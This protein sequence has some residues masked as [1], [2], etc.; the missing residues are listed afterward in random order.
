MKNTIIILLLLGCFSTY[1]LPV[2]DS[3]S[4]G[5]VGVDTGRNHRF[6]ICLETGNAKVFEVFNTGS[7]TTHT[8]PHTF[9]NRPIIG[10]DKGAF[11][12]THFSSVEIGNNII[13]IR[14]SAFHG[15]RL[16]SVTIPKSV[17][18]IGE[19]AFGASRNLKRISVDED[20]PF[21]TEKS[22]V[23][24]NKEKTILIAYPAGKEGEKYIIPNSVEVIFGYAFSETN[25]SFIV[26]PESVKKIRAFSFQHNV[27]LKKIS[28]FW[29]EPEMLNVSRFAFWRFPFYACQLVID[30]LADRVSNNAAL[31]YI[32]LE[33]PFGTKERYL[34]LEPWKHFQIIER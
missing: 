34:A 16:D 30:R 11:A 8:I 26:I 28:V 18:F 22:G 21:F 15:S 32:V 10:I 24:F 5:T 23:L 19:G 25:L 13:Y 14:E 33:V 17:E 12:R 1:C 3:R 27:N 4:F 31:K 9:N 7:A 20:N 2:W 6:T 29:Q